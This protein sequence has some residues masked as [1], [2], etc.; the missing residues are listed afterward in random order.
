MQNIYETAREK[1]R[2]IIDGKEGRWFDPGEYEYRILEFFKE[3]VPLLLQGSPEEAQKFLEPLPG[4]PED[5]NSLQTI[6]AALRR[7]IHLMEFDEDKD[8]QDAV[9]KAF[10]AVLAL[11]RRLNVNNV[12]D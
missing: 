3:Q 9:R 8:L 7:V 6:A 12:R 1:Y 2:H 5:A 11:C 4:S 10:D